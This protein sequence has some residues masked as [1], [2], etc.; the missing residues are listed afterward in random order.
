MTRLTHANGSMLKAIPSARLR[1]RPPIIK[2]SKAK[3][4][5][6]SWTQVVGTLIGLYAL[7]MSPILLE[8]GLARLAHMLSGALGG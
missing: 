1:T 2:V 6:L 3:E 8:I 4:T 5:G 7:V